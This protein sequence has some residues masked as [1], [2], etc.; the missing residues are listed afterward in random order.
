MQQVSLT[1]ELQLLKCLGHLEKYLGLHLKNTKNTK[2]FIKNLHKN[3]TEIYT[4]QVELEMTTII[5]TQ[6]LIVQLLVTSA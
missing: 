1:N 6:D 3:K 4:I 2:S 5:F